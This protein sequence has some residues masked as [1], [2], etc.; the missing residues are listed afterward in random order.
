MNDLVIGTPVSGNVAAGEMKN[1]RLHIVSGNAVN[2]SLAQTSSTG[3]CDLY[4]KYNQGNVTYKEIVYW[5]FIEPSIWS[6][7][8]A[9]VTLHN[10]SI[11]FIEGLRIFFEFSFNNSFKKNNNYLITPLIFYH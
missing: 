2:V 6:W 1:Y 3:D 10:H 7:D 9:N 4:I 11:I 8:Y 5:K